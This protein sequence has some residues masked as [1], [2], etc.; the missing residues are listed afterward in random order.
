MA[1]LAESG[2][3]T[4]DGEIN[5][6]PAPSNATRAVPGAP[7]TQTTIGLLNG[8]DLRQFHGIAALVGGR[9]GGR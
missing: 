6:S 1:G 3:A 5:A 7:D 9:V 8:T 2:I 4:T